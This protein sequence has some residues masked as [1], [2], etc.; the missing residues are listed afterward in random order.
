MRHRT[1]S[2]SLRKHPFL[3]VLRRRGRFAKRAK[4][5]QRRRARRNGYFRRLLLRQTFC[6]TRCW[7]RRK[8]MGH[9]TLS[10]KFPSPLCCF[11]LPSLFFI[12]GDPGAD[13]AAE[14]NSKRAEKNGTKNRLRR[15][16]SFRLP[17]RLSHVDITPVCYCDT[18]IR[19]T[20]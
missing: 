19:N 7:R 6:L 14:E 8:L 17:C 4:R 20:E 12:L 13:S 5:P 10:P 11:T 15:C 18:I 9:A 16:F 3:F 2:A 1:C